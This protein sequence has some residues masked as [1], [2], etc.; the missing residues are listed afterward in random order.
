MYLFIYLLTH[1]VF[2]LCARKLTKYEIKNYVLIRG[3]DIGT[4]M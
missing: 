2:Y 4:K 1:C 3:T